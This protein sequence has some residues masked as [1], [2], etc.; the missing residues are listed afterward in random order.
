M[1]NQKQISVAAGRFCGS[2]FSLCECLIHR[3]APHPKQNFCGL[4]RILQEVMSHMHFSEVI[5]Y[6]ACVSAASLCPSMSSVD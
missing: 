2:L 3:N 4:V 6:I 5:F 1:T